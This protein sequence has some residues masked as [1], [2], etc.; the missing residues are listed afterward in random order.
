M[1]ALLGTACALGGIANTPMAQAQQIVATQDFNIPAQPLGQAIN[2]FI[3]QS[4]WQVSYPSA[5][6][7]GLRSDGISGKMAPEAAL[8]LI[9]GNSGLMATS[10]APGTASIVSL[11]FGADASDE[12]AL[13]LAPIQIRANEFAA[14]DS[15]RIG[16]KT[17]TPVKEIPQSISIISTK[18][19]EQRTH[20][21]LGDI[22]SYTPGLRNTDYP[23]GQGIGA[24]LYIRGFRALNSRNFY[25]NGLRRS[26]NAY[27]VSMET[28]GLEQVNVLRGPSSSLY[29][30]ASP[31]GIIDMRSKRPQDEPFGEAAVEVGSFDRRQLTLDFGDTLNESGTLKYRLTLLQR[32]SGTQIDHADDDSTYIAPALTWEPSDYTKLTLLTHYHKWNKGGSEQS[33]PYNGT[34]INRNP[35]LT[36]DLYLGIPGLTK[37]E[38]E[39]RA[40]G[41]E[42]E[43][44]FNNGWELQSSARYTHTE[45]DY[46]WSFT[47]PVAPTNDRFVNVYTQDRPRI[48]ENLTFDINANREFRLG[49]TKHRVMVGASYLWSDLRENRTNTS[50]PLLVDISNPNYNGYE[51]NWCTQGIYCRP[52]NDTREELEHWGIYIQDQMTWDKLQVTGSLRYDEMK[53][54]STFYDSR[55][56]AGLQGAM[57]TYETDTDDAVTGRLGVSY[58]VTPGVF[59]YGSYSTSFEP[60]PGAGADGKLFK[61][62]TGK[63]FELGVKYEPAHYDA[64]FTASIYQLTQEDVAVPDTVNRNFLTQTGEVRSRGVELE[65]K[66]T[67]G[68]G[69]TLAAAYG[70]TDPE[71]AKDNPNVNGISKEGTRVESVPYHTASLWLNREVQNGTFTGLNLGVGVR[72]VGSSLTPVNAS[73]GERFKVPSYTLVDAVVKYDLG[74]ANS[75]LDGV[76][77]TLGVTNLT[78][79]EYYSPGFYSDSVLAG[80]RRAVTFNVAYTW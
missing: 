79:K 20:S 3:Q 27:D 70:Y 50:N 80:K 39:T 41:Y 78:D 43:H 8:Q 58:E 60:V 56:L 7:R 31:G 38:G 9:L 33:L 67:L 59:A 40:F 65:A 71:V 22:L 68:A 69:W 15:Y 73:T 34:V 61:P 10:P 5:A 45:L 28:F 48:S 51:P 42:F 18:E 21:D 30:D 35:H 62:T 76:K 2:A 19:L 57:D 55:T 24:R 1:A 32:D 53:S 77:L 11:D 54:T 47:W 26:F 72:Y 75:D 25:L 37:W 12:E 13:R 29:G 4:G 36:S 44:L 14:F 49:A 66:T 64:L 6:V 46:L 63:Q 16:T 74:G 52:W 23:G 17:K